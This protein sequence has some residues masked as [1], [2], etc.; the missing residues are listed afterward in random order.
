MRKKIYIFIAAIIFSFILWGS[1][2]LSDYYYTNVD[3]K[4]VLS[5]FPDG[6]T[7]GSNIPENV[8]L[9]VKGQGWKLVSLNIG[10]DSDF[11]VSVNADSGQ[12][13]IGT[14]SNLTNNRWILSDLEVIDIAPDTIVF[15][16]EKVISKL[17]PV[18]PQLNLDFKP[19]YGL[20]SDLSFLPDS[21]N[22]SGPVG[23]MRF[24]EHIPTKKIELSSLDN[25]IQKV[26][27]LPTL[28]GFTFSHKNINVT[29]DV[30]RI[31]DRQ[32]NDIEVEVL[33][34]PPDK[35]VLLFPNKI[36]CS[37]RGGIEVLGKLS[38]EKFKSYLYYKDVVLDTVGSVIP[39]LEAPP[40]TAVLFTKPER[41]RYVIK[42]F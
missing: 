17:L 4:L 12:K 11:R 13:L 42:S 21:I 6:Y 36:G 20:A 41:L 34:V 26:I 40:N 16:V 5:D 9:R 7:T 24:M 37:V 27:P 29:L 18:V 14:A 28:R 33:D 35:E 32:I 25:K 23:M 31:V 2:S 19:G 15:K 1:I 30:Q 39:Q 10:A 22:V 38:R 3:L 8:S